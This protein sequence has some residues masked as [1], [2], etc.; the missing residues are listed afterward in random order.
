MRNLILSKSLL[1]V[2]MDGLEMFR[3]GFTLLP[4]GQLGSFAKSYFTPPSHS[5]QESGQVAPQVHPTQN[6]NS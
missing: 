5:R 1:H 3:R 2:E 6:C 4:T